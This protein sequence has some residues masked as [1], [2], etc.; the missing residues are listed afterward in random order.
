MIVGGHSHTRV[1]SPT[2]VGNTVIVQAWEHGKTLGVL[3]ITLTDGK[4]TS[5]DGRLEDIRPDR[6]EP[7]PAVLSLVHEVQ[8]GGGCRP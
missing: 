7:D 5:I 1:D 3:D 6:G 2:R 8:A 4:I